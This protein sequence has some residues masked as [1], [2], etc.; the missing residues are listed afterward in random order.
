MKNVEGGIALRSWMTR[1]LSA[2]TKWWG[3]ASSTIP[4]P[5]V[6]IE[7]I[8]RVET[9]GFDAHAFRIHSLAG[10]YLETARHL[11][12]NRETIDEVNPKRLFVRAWVAQLPEKQALEQIG[13]EELGRAVGG[14][15]APGDALLIATGWDR[16]WNRPGFIEECPYFGPGTMEWIVSQK[17]SL[18]G[19]DVPSIQDPRTMEGDL[20]ELAMF[21]SENRLLLAPLVGLREAGEDAW[22]LAALPLRV[23]GTCSAPCRALLF[24]P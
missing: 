24:Q 6:E 17:I 14:K 3:S 2:T 9:E 16:Q 19:V 15:L 11:F 1:S 12:Q 23:P 20:T 21:Y 10:T 22:F 13:P 4:F 8:A 5:K 7:R 18:L